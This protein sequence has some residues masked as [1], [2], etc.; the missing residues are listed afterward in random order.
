V[1]HTAS[2]ENYNLEFNTFIITLYLH[3]YLVHDLFTHHTFFDG[4]VKPCYVRVQ[5]NN[6]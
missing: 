5:Q 6:I 1:S 3:M 4:I 2:E